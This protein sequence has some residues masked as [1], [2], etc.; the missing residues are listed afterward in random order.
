[1]NNTGIISYDLGKV[2][3]QEVVRTCERKQIMDTGQ[4]MMS[5][6]VIQRIV[7]SLTGRHHVYGGT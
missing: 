3:V 2:K 6:P 1:M 5:K 7:Q 4:V